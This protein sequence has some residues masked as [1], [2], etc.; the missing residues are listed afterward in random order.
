MAVRVGIIGAGNMGKTHGEVLKEDSRVTIVGIS[1]LIPS[2]AEELASAL[3]SRAFPDPGALLNA[4]IDAVYVTTPNTKHGPSVLEALSRNI[5]VFSEKPM[6][7][8]L[9]EAR[10]ILDATRASKTV[11][12]VGHNRRFAPAYKYQK[13]QIEAGFTPYLVNAKQNDGDW[14]NP[15]WITDLSLTGGFLYESSVH[16]LDL[17]RWLIGEVVSVQARARSNVYDVQND[18]AILMTF[19]GEYFAVC[20]SSAH[21]SWAF[22]TEHVEI[23]GHHAAIRTEE[24]DRVIH[25]PGLNQQPLTFDYSQLPRAEKWGYREE[26]AAFISACLGEVPPA[27]NALE[28]YR[29]IELCEACYLSADNGGEMVKLPLSTI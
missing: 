24:L 22:P 11:Y 14:L 26:D 19:A 8:T 16:V 5:N 21:A 25:S 10:L 28:A 9:K 1:D 12:Q 2:R 29:S 6:A 18:F 7:T 17:L 23:V 15:P 20:S 4:D 3:G 13:Q 27:V